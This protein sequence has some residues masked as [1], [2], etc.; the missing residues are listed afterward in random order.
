MVD[1]HVRSCFLGAALAAVLLSV[2]LDA[3]EPAATLVPD[4][5]GLGSGTHVV[6]RGVVQLEAGMELQGGRGSEQFTL[7]Q[8]LFRVGVAGLELRVAPGSVVVVEEELGREDPEVGVKIPLA[9]GETRV[10][11]MASLSLPWGSDVFSAREERVSATLLLDRPLTGLWGLSVNAGA[12]FPA[13]EPGDAGLALIVTPSRAV[14]GVEGLSVYGGYAGF[15]DDGRKEHILEAGGA[16]L[17]DSD[18]Q[19]DLNLGFM[20]SSERLFV[21]VGVSHRWR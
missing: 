9:R 5:P 8:S 13:S 14:D 4:R 11:A 7:G 3:Q 19:F 18:T 21:G 20:T 2:G 16:F 15:Y 17:S 10:S 12:S 1:T 6:G